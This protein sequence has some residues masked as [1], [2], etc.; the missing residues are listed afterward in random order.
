LRCRAIVVRRQLPSDPFLGGQ[1]HRG[2]WSLDAPHE[3]LIEEV[4]SEES[5]PRLEAM[6]GIGE[7]L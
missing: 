1:H 6:P 4:G 2:G 5:V 7:N 3:V